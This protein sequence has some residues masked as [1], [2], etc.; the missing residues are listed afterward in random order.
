[1]GQ[2]GGMYSGFMTEDQCTAFSF[3]DSRALRMRFGDSVMVS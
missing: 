2:F 1:M 3:N